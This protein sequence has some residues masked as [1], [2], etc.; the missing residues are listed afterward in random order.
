M[1]L[2][3]KI[4]KFSINTVILGFVIGFRFVK[5][6][7]FWLNLSAFKRMWLKISQVIMNHAH[8]PSKQLNIHHDSE[9]GPLVKEVLCVDS[10]PLTTAPLAVGSPI[11]GRP[12]DPASLSHNGGVPTA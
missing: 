9:K 8:W 10:S 7:Y 11:S 4:S 1:K 3:L 12:A 2:F 5:I 6:I